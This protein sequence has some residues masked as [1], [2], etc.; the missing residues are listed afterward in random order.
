[1]RGTDDRQPSLF[2]AVADAYA[3]GEPISNAALYQHLVERGAI[4]QSEL[5]QRTAIGRSSKGHSL[6]K[7]KVRWIQQTLRQL[8]LLERVP[9]QTGIWSVK[10]TQDVDGFQIAPLNMVRVAFSTDMGLALWADAS[11]FRKLHLP[12]HLVLTSPP[13][14]LSNPRSYGN[15]SPAQFT[16]FI[17]DA[18]EPLV[19]NLAAGG[20]ICLNLSNDIFL[21]RSPAR[22]T[23]LERLTIALEDRLGLQLM[24]RLVWHNPNKQPGPTHW[25]CQ[26]RIQLVHTYEPVL[27]FCN[28]P[29]R[30][31]ADNRRVLQLHKPAQ[32][33]LM[34]RGGETRTATYGDGAYT[35]R[36]GSFG[37]ETAGSIPRN[38]IPVSHDTLA[39]A[40]LKKAVM[41]EG[42]PAHGALMPRTLASFLIRFLVP[43]GSRVIEPFGGWGTT[44]EQA[45]LAG[46][47]WIMTER[48][49]QYLGAAAI[50]MKQA[51]GFHSHMAFN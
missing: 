32:R 46:C 21:S 27:W 13:Y 1:M 50:R 29:V 2:S 37:Q 11:V 8:G 18:L 23:Y 45:E 33:L 39:T 25:A 36:P 51:P 4:T 17:C 6:V 19:R 31:L 48:V 47:E 20:S 49:A 12:F 10:K 15:P 22:S 38:V 30:C 3:G 43:P 5:Q 7:R 14:P 16:D 40:S 44:I 34:E 26:Q 9:G 24:D 28:D 42:L 41:A 35:L